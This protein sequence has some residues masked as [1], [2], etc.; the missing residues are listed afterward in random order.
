MPDPVGLT[1]LAKQLNLAQRCSN[2]DE[3]AKVVG[4]K[5]GPHT[6][7]PGY[8]YAKIPLESGGYDHFAYLPDSTS[9]ANAVPKLKAD[10]T[11]NCQPTGLTWTK[12]FT[13]SYTVGRDDRLAQSSEY[14]A[15]NPTPAGFA[16]QGAVNNH[17]MTSDAIMRGS[18]IFQE[19]FAQGLTLTRSRHQYDQPGH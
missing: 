9:I 15:S 11:G 17:H 19:L 3:I 12:K 2:W 8:K 14:L 1:K 4:K 7:P 13:G 5:V 18:A 10:A 16:E 6:L